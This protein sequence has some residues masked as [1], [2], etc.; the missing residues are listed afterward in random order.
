MK[1]IVLAGGLGTRLYPMTK[2]I[3]KHLL[4][5]YDKPMIFYP[6]ATLIQAGI[7]DILLV[8][9]PQETENFQKLL[10]NGNTFGIN[11]QYGIQFVPNGI[12]GA[13]LLCREFI[14]DDACTVILGDNFFDGNSLIDLMKKAFSD[15]ENGLASVFLS[16]V[17]DPCQFGVAELNEKGNI[18]SLEEKPVYPKSDLAITGLYCYPRGVCEQIM[19]LSPSARGE[20]EMTALNDL[21]RK[22]DKLKTCLMEKDSTWMD[23]GTPENLFRAASFIREKVLQGIS[24]GLSEERKAKQ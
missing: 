1:G 16:H 19:H 24:V 5:V 9:A 6:L 7:R 15:A 22:Q 23:M 12:A 11:L 20:L 18:L 21:Y 3:S 4:P 13:L 10:G 14:G 2:I 8:T 17:A